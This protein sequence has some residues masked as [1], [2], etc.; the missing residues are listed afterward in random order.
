MATQVSSKKI[1]EAKNFKRGRL[2]VEEWQL[3]AR[4]LLRHL[5]D[6][7]VLQ[8]SPLS[9][10]VTVEQ[11]AKA[12]YPSGVV[13][14]GR[15]LNALTLEC[16]R[17]I[18]EELNGHAGVAKLKAFITLTREGRGVSEAGRA[19]GLSPEHVCRSFKRDL[20]RLLAEKLMLTLR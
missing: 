5:D 11:R 18:E 4:Y 7:I 20:V 15:Y 6:P 14:K 1:D 19:L 3:R 17:E 8:R 9:R 12:K 13:A 2:A 16:I 10:L